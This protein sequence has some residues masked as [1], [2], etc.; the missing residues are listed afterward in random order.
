MNAGLSRSFH[1]SPLR[2][3]MAHAHSVSH[4]STRR[5]FF[6]N[7]LVPILSDPPPWKPNSTSGRRTKVL[8][9][10]IGTHG[11]TGTLPGIK[12]LQK[13]IFMACPTPAADEDDWPVAAVTGIMG[14]DGWVLSLNSEPLLLY[15]SL[16]G[17]TFG[18]TPQPVFPQ[19]GAMV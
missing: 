9:C 18:K 15:L 3:R 11:K 10:Q 6:I 1:T 8:F 17:F 16:S 2:D 14:G 19:G 5:F 13:M 7:N 4:P 12:G